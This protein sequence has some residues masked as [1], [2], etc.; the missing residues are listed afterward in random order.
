MKGLLGEGDQVDAHSRVDDTLLRH[1]GQVPL[2]L[3]RVALFNIGVVM[4][5]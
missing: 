3:V 5:M 1:Q 2:N 4:V